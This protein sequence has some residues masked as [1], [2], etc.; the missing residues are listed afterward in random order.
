[1]RSKRSRIAVIGA[2]T[3]LAVTGTMTMTAS[4]H[5]D[6][7]PASRFCSFSQTFYRGAEE[8]DNPPADTCVTT[9]VDE[10]AHSTEN[11]TTH[12]AVLFLDRNC[13]IP[14]G[15]QVQPLSNMPVDV[16]RSFRLDA[17]G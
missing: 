10:A 7:C 13:T 16:Y 9:H 6:A 8:V 4:A 11:N 3:V 15:A 2:A 1:M 17:T 12:L 14:S 5:A